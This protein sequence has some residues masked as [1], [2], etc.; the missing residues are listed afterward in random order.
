MRVVLFITVFVVA[1]RSWADI[2][3]VAM[4]DKWS[5]EA[6]EAMGGLEDGLHHRAVHEAPR[7]AAVEANGPVFSHRGNQCQRFTHIKRRWAP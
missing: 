3:A 2:G 6:A 7:H 5:A 1:V 4:P